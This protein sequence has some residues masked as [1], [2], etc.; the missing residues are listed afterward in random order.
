MFSSSDGEISNLNHLRRWFGLQINIHLFQ[1]LEALFI[2]LKYKR[3]ITKEPSQVTWLNLS[4]DAVQNLF[5]FFGE[6]GFVR[7]LSDI[8]VYMVIMIFWGEMCYCK[9]TLALDSAR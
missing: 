8:N 7:Q 3:G 6:R 2:A 4:C 1:W 9:E 5:C